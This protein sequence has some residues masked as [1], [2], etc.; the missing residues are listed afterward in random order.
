M[1]VRRVLTRTVF[2]FHSSFAETLSCTAEMGSNHSATSRVPIFLIPR[3]R[4]T[5]RVHC[6]C[7]VKGGPEMRVPPHYDTHAHTHAANSSAGIS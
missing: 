1:C 7:I 6:E 2:S 3:K 4:T 5:F